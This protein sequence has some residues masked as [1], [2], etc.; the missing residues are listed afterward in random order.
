MYLEIAS[1]IDQLDEFDRK[2]DNEKADEKAN[3]KVDE[4]AK[5][6]NKTSNKTSNEICNKV[7]GIYDVVVNTKY[8][9][10]EKKVKLVAM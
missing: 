3:E 10:V 4:K 7:F 6:S 9:T 8:N 5:K 1:L 2:T